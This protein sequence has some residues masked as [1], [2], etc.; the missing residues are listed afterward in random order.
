MPPSPHVSP[1]DTWQVRDA[2]IDALDKWVGECA[3][4]P[5]LPL[6]PRALAMEAP[7]GRVKLIGW[8]ALFIPTLPPIDV[9]SSCPYDPLVPPL[10]KALD[11]RTNDVRMAAQAAL[12]ALLEAGVSTE[13]LHSCAGSLSLAT[14]AK[15][16]PILDKLTTA[17]AVSATNAAP[18][19]HHTA[20]PPAAP[21]A[22][23]SVGHT[24]AMA[25]AAPPPRP[26]L[27]SQSARSG[28]ARP[29]SAAVLP[30]ARTGIAK[31]PANRAPALAKP[32]PPPAP[33]HPAAAAA[34]T[35]APPKSPAAPSPRRAVGPGTPGACAPGASTPSSTSKPMPKKAVALGMMLGRADAH[36]KAA[37]HTL[38]EVDAASVTVRATIETLQS[39]VKQDPSLLVP[40]HSSLL[41][42]LCRRLDLVLGAGDISLTKRVIALSMEC[43]SCPPLMEAVT[44]LEA[45]LLISQLLDRLMDRRLVDFGDMAGYLLKTINL[46][47]LKLLQHAPRDATLNAILS[48]LADKSRRPSDRQLAELL[49]KCLWKLIR[50]LGADTD[51]E[52]AANPKKSF[53]LP[54]L[55]TRLHELHAA[56]NANAGQPLSVTDEAMAAVQFVS[57]LNEA[58]DSILV[59]LLTLRGYDAV[60]QA[61]PPAADAGLAV[62]VDELHAAGAGST[63]APR[64]AATAPSAAPPSASPPAS[65]PNAL[66]P[67]VQA[68]NAA[69]DAAAPNSSSPAI[70]SIRGVLS[71]AVDAADVEEPSEGAEAA[72][73]VIAGATDSVAS[74]AMA[75]LHAMKQKYNIQTKPSLPPAR[76]ADAADTR[77]DTPTAPSDASPA[78]K[79]P[80]AA[81]DEEAEPS[82]A[83]EREKVISPSLNVAALRTRLARLKKH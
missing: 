71:P 32:P 67:T 43:L 7:A 37:I 48:C 13:A 68:L 77:L 10:L 19:A 26:T 54:P 25:D 57:Q 20:P 11:D 44:E 3:F 22:T 75:R 5:L 74:S 81:E 52:S 16:K 12:A 21:V 56:A 76:V 23:M 58:A 49:L 65:S 41:A 15:L 59:T 27:G 78:A 40:S 14:R 80:A 34:S 55:L 35:S 66:A 83:D 1:G 72:A 62:R 64:P 63:A 46:L 42:A 61:L 6:L 33:P 70:D 82:A 50:S 28:L 79:P 24:T 18:S 31:P 39:Q 45:K 69:F 4:E 36:V 30:T 47:M 8:M 2:A 9:G 29:A 51:D 17:A 73:G 53:A 60:K 38:D